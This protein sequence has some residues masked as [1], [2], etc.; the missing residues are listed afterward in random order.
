MHEKYEN[1]RFGSHG[2]WLTQTA[3]VFLKSFG[4]YENEN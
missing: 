4:A 2:S 1:N 3:N